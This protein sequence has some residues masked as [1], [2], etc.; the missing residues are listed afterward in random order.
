[1]KRKETRNQ[2]TIP[3]HTPETTAVSRRSFIKGAGLAAG[4]VAGASLAASAALGLGGCSTGGT[5]GSASGAVVPETVWDQEADVVVVGF[6]GA[7]A[8][9]SIEAA[10]AGAQVLLI[11]KNAEKSHLCN[12]LMAGGIFHSPDKSG[13]PAAL[14]Q[15]LRAM[16][17][18]E[19]LPTKT[20]PE[21]S[22][23]FVD[24]IVE[25][26]AALEPENLDFMKGLDPDYSVI[27]SG[28]AAFPQFPGAE[29][30][31]YKAYYSGYGKNFTN[32]DFPTIDLPKE[33]TGSGL[34]FFNCLKNGVQD[35]SDLITVMWETPA[36]KLIKN[37]QGEIIGVKAESQGKELRIKARKAVVLASGGYE[38][39]EEMRRAFLEGP[40][41]TGWA[42]YGTTS[43]EGD[44][45][46]MGI[47]AGAQL[48]KVGKAASR[49]IWSC[50][51]VKHNNMQVGAIADTVGSAGTIVV[52]SKGSRFMDETLITKDPSRYFSYK[53][54]V[55][56]DITTLTFPNDPSYMIFDETKRLAGPLTNLS[57][58]TAG[59]G[60]VPWDEKNEI[61][62][63]RG[64]IYKAD[65]IEEL[66]Q[67]ISSTHAQNKGQMDAA[68]LADTMSKYQ[69]IVET[70][71]D[72]EFGRTSK[73]RDP[74]TAQVVDVGFQPISTP[75]FYALPLVAGGPNTKGG[76][77]ADGDRHVI[78]WDNKPIPRLYTAGEMS[79]CLK[80][81]YQG[82]GNLTECIVC[83]RIA[84]MNATAETAWDQAE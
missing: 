65:T 21:Q 56:M 82:G 57:L 18:G 64:W 5:A 10:N 43:N 61:P 38:Y 34:A 6:G 74:K 15:Y 70:G 62:I 8:C 11:E 39:S 76:L 60:L 66:A 20:E 48:A 44:G 37:D 19:N 17:S 41:I 23:L 16:F 81:V 46:R 47:E 50:P 9:A 77:Q 72:K 13:D 12:T 84:G 73:A 42:F 69:Q 52:N 31:G 36:K 75:P 35:R 59:F 55:K 63:E 24:G 32:P 29:E 28:G 27:E 45:I 40:G 79:S 3:D 4:A 30:S 53:N 2:P 51:D 68:V 80:F 83:G 26:F 1:M 33:E 78:D 14:K 54:A 58:S 49:F 7:G 22:P 67:K 71:V 25:K